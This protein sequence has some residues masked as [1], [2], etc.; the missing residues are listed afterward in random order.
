MLA[1]RHYRALPAVLSSALLCIAAVTAGCGEDEAA[2][3]QLAQARAEQKAATA[4]KEA[5]EQRARAAEAEAKQAQQEVTEARVAEP[6]GGQN[7]DA[8]ARV[9]VPGDLVG[10]RLDVAED[11]LRSVGL[12]Y[13]EVGGGAFGI[14]NPSAWVVCR[15]KPNSGATLAEGRHVKLIVDREGGC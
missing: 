14:V 9:K 8:R 4:E 15:T 3:A 13:S 6:S 7:S 1:T 12:R 11:E 10:E 5:A 2:K